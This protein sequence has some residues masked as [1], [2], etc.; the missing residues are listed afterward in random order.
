MAEG[1]GFE[2]PVR[3]PAQW[4]SRPPVSTAHASLRG[5]FLVYLCGGRNEIGV[6]LVSSQFDTQPCTFTPL[7]N[8]PRW[9][10][11]QPPS[12]R[13]LPAKCHMLGMR[14][15]CAL[16]GTEATRRSRS[17]SRKSIPALDAAAKSRA[18]FAHPIEIAKPAVRSQLPELQ[19]A[20]RLANCSKPLRQAPPSRSS[21]RCCRKQRPQ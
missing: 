1:E 21:V 2:P 19:T 10:L 20:P 3:F 4:F 13:M 6:N 16:H 12:R 8:P 11:V 7:R 5:M 14:A 15:W 9:P 17:E 18:A